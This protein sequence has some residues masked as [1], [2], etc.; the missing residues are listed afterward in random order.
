MID[1]WNENIGLNPDTERKRQG[2]FLQP[3]DKLSLKERGTVSSCLVNSFCTVMHV[4]HQLHRKSWDQPP[5]WRSSQKYLG[6]QDEG[7]Q[8][9]T[10][11]ENAKDYA[12]K[13]RLRG[14]LR[15]QS[16]SS[17]G[18]KVCHLVSFLLDR[19]K[20]GGCSTVSS[21]IAITWLGTA[22]PLPFP[23]YILC[24]STLS[25]SFD[26]HGLFASLH[27]PCRS[28]SLQK[29]IVS[30]ISSSS[31]FSNVYYNTWRDRR[32]TW[33]VQFFCVKQK[34]ENHIQ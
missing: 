10:R 13:G 29:V 24:A 12:L 17:I 11:E 18:S 22:I 33:I 27:R 20:R 4:Q 7:F 5:G 32:A 19:K 30:Q 15:S 3:D 31:N 14:L 6:E 25:K 8:V 9:S 2:E 21:D 16:S 34:E 23:V 1:N 26:I 28:H